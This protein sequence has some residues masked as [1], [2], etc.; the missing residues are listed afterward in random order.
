VQRRNR[1][2]YGGQ[3]GLKRLSNLLV[4]DIAIVIAIIIDLLVIRLTAIECALELTD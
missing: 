2:E 3:N 1:W 4:I